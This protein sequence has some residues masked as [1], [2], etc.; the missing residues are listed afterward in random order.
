MSES[1]LKELIAKRM[2]AFADNV[3]SNDFDI[4]RSSWRSN[5]NFGGAYTYASVQAR[6]KDW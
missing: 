3:S 1:Y 5:S 4:I 6:P 2:N